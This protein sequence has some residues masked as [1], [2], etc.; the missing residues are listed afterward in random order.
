M[1]FS[2]PSYE[3]KYH[4]K[5]N[6]EKISEAKVLGNLSETYGH[7]TPVLQEMIDGK[8]VPTPTAVYRIKGFAEISID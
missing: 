2:M 7:I 5:K 6:W 1:L 3:V 8:Q 4:N